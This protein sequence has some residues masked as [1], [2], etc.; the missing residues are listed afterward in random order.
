MHNLVFARSKVRYVIDLFTRLLSGTTRLRTCL[1]TLCHPTCV[2]SIV[3]ADI[4]LDYKN[5]SLIKTYFHQSGLSA[6]AEQHSVHKTKEEGDKAE[7]DE[8][9]EAHEW[10]L[11]PKDE[12]EKSGLVKESGKY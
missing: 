12:N 3:A 4:L 2:A 1:R 5:I 6:D 11:K 10:A 9:D 8:I 7:E